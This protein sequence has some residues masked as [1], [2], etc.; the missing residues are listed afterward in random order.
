[1]SKEFKKKLDV[2]LVILAL[3][4]F[5]YA[6]VTGLNAKRVKEPNLAD[7]LMSSMAAEEARAVETQSEETQAE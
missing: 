6:S 7:Q 3:I 4:I 2:L 5:A 1:M